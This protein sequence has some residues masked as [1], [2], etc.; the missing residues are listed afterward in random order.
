[1]SESFGRTRERNFN[2]PP[3]ANESQKIESK[4]K[5]ESCTSSNQSVTYEVVLP[6]VG[7]SAQRSSTSN[8]HISRSTING[9]GDTKWVTARTEMTSDDDNDGRQRMAT[10]DDG[11]QAKTR[12]DNEHVLASAPAASD[13]ENDGARTTT[14]TR[15]RQ[16]R[17]ASAPVAGTT[18]KDTQRVVIFGGNQQRSSMISDKETS[19]GGC[20]SGSAPPSNARLSQR[21]IT[22]RYDERRQDNDGDGE[23]GNKRMA[24]QS[25]M[26]SG[27][28][29]FF[30]LGGGTTKGDEC[31]IVK[32]PMS[33]SFGRTR[34][35]NFNS[36]I[37]Q[38]SSISSF[39]AWTSDGRHGGCLGRFRVSGDLQVRVLSRKAMFSGYALFCSILERDFGEVKLECRK[40]AGRE[41]PRTLN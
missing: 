30:V 28:T 35:R 37:T 41:T 9:N 40:T 38:S 13:N 6:M 29:S 16:R 27:T 33:E 22:A 14:I 2:T 39:A 18:R 26:D 32:P 19:R 4:I 34:E 15:E 12:N 20:H 10:D 11:R 36:D 25:S 7:I 3:R 8:L 23:T 31:T 21:A 5:Q 24:S 1:M 17:L